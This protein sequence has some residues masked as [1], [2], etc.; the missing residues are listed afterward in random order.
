MKRLYRKALM[1]RL[2]HEAEGGISGALAGVAVGAI[3]GAPGAIAGALIGGAVGA[4]AFRALDSAAVWRDEK[5]ERLDEEIG[6]IGGDLGAPNL[7]HPPP[8]SGA[9]SAASVGVVPAGDGTA[10]PPEGPMQE[11]D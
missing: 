1:R 7:L 6:V 10:A 8:V 11:P 2:E 3:A 4:F 5:D 9:Y